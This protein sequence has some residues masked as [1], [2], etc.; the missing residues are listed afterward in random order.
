MTIGDDVASPVADARKRTL[1]GLESEAV[2]LRAEVAGLQVELARLR[3]RTPLRSE[4]DLLEAKQQLV[5]AAM[6]AE[7]VAESTA[8]LRRSVPLDS[9][10]RNAELLEA[11]SRLVA[12]TL[13]AQQGEARAREAQGRAIA[14]MATAAHELRNPLTPIRLAAGMLAEARGDLERFTRLRDI[15]EAEVEHIVRL[16]DDL[17]EGARVA[18]GKLSL[19]YAETSLAGVLEAAAATCRPAI[20]S[21]KQKLVVEL[22]PGDAMH[23]AAD[24][25]RLLQVFTNLL[26]NASK[27]TP[28][29]GRIA[30][31]AARIPTALTVRVEDSGIGIP[32]GALLRVFEMFFQE[33]AAATLRPNGLGIGLAIVRE[34]VEAHGGTIVALSEGEGQG[35]TFA[36]TLPVAV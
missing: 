27:Y 1:E 36:V 33:P 10:T 21:R 26:D 25:S 5:L 24:R 4:R 9:R 23:L 22:P 6:R 14:M 11:N 2:S 13:H 29:G 3:E 35:S 7:A 16:V 18:S 32:P 20:E 31:L 17:V 34:L 28:E 12:S 19:Q 15:I 30:L 8:A